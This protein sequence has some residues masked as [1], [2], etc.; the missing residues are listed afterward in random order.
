[1]ADMFEAF[2]SRT[3]DGLTHLS[4]L[5]LPTARMRF[6]ICGGVAGGAGI[7]AVPF[8]VSFSGAVVMTGT[9]NAD[10]EVSV[11]VLEGAVLRIFDTD[12]TLGFQTALPAADTLAGEQ[13]RLEVIGYFTG[14]LTTPL[15]AT[16]TGDGNDSSM[17]QQAITN[18]QMDQT[19]TVDGLIG[20]QTRG[21]LK[22][23]AGE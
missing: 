17:L 5:V 20:P 13:K 15:A 14:Y 19:L 22:T 3:L 23:A 2:I 8:T 9:T 18:F 4:T 10:G 7:D 12:Y 21:R 6:Q 1:M 11:P 16:P